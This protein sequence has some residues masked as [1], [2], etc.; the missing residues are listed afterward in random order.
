MEVWIGF[1][2]NMQVLNIDKTHV[3]QTLCEFNG[4]KEIKRLS[5]EL[6]F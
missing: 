4:C 5:P 3:D 1:T 6:F 2:Y